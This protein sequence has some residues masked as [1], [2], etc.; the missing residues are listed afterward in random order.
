MITTVAGNGVLGY[1]PDGPATGVAIDPYA[2]IAVDAGGNIYFNDTFNNIVRKIT[3]DGNLTTIVGTGKAGSA[4]DNQ[5]AV[6]AQLNNP[7]GLALDASGNIYISDSLNH[8]VRM[9]SSSKGTIATIVGS[10]PAGSTGDGG[11]ALSATLV[12]PAGLALDAKGNLYISDDVANNVR[13]VNTGQIITTIA[14]TGTQGFSGDNGAATKAALSAPF[15]ISVDPTGNA[16][17]ADSGNYRLRKVANAAAAGA[18]ITTAAGNATFRF[19][20]DGFPAVDAQL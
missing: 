19:G 7:S 12:F 2:G 8:K 13:M 4:G 20:G 14:G 5:P 3:P 17:I 16:Y 15:G 10:G 1:S 6:Q 11:S 18:T 9:V